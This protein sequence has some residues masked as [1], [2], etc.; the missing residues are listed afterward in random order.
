MRIYT[1][2]LLSASPTP[3]GSESQARCFQL[4]LA[5]ALS[6]QSIQAPLLHSPGAAEP[7]PTL[8]W[9]GG[10]VQPR[11][12]VPKSKPKLLHKIHGFPLPC[13]RGLCLAPIPALGM[14][15]MRC[16]SILVPP[17]EEVDPASSLFPRTSSHMH[18]HTCTWGWAEVGCLPP[19]RHCRLHL[20]PSSEGYYRFEKT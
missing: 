16:K 6:G 1:T 3:R 12:L 19:S 20:S 11:S 13:W 5:D 4:L 8:T 17:A 15:Q 7:G 18:L 9:A 2:C 10:T 14:A